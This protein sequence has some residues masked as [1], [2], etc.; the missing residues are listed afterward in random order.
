MRASNSSYWEI[1]ERPR[2][3]NRATLC[4]DHGMNTPTLKLKG[5]DHINFACSDMDRTLRFWESLGFACSF[6][7]TLHNP[8]RF[9]FF[10]DCG[11]G[12]LFSYWYWPGRKLAP[13]QSHLDPHHAGFY[14]LAFHV[15]TEEEL[16]EVHARV[17]AAG[18][19]ASEITGRHLFDK[20]FYFDDPDGI[21]F[22]F[23][24]RVLDFQGPIDHD[25]QGTLSPAGPG[26]KIGRRTLDGPVHWETKF[27]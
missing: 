16:E 12:S 27:K 23:A 3:E 17:R 22:E 5:I 15:D 24:C 1:P 2:V 4:S 14:H 11:N 20:S 25:G 8:E 9:H 10:I 13:P 21:Q 6:K 26:A 7:L 18:V 19:S